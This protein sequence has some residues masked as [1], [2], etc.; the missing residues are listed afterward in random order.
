VAPRRD[1][2]A[3]CGEV[4]RPAESAFDTPDFIAD[5][6]DP[7]YRVSDASVH[8]ACFLVWEWRKRFVARFN[9]VARAMVAPDGSYPHMTSEGD[10][11]RRAGHLPPTSPPA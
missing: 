5:E 4:I 2:C 1:V 7:F 11:V 9:R 3:L 8:R 6:R 10:V